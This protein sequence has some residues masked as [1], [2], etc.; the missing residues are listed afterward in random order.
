MTLATLLMPEVLSL[1][2]VAVLHSF[3]AHLQT[4]Y[5]L[6]ALSVRMKRYCNSDR[7]YESLLPVHSTQVHSVDIF[8]AFPDRSW[9][10]CF[11]N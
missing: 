6:A 7:Y 10:P 4:G 11:H 1:A 5:S 2:A 8:F 3:H 9:S